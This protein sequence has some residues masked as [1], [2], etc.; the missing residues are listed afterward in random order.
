MSTNPLPR[1]QSDAERELLLHVKAYGLPEPVTQFR[2]H[3]TR[4]W[5]ADLAFVEQKVLVEVE[6]GAFRGGRHT[7]GTGFRED[8]I[9]YAEAMCLGY[10]I[11]RVMPEQIRDG[12]AIQWL[13]K[14]LTRPE[15]QPPR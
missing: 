14:I 13:S 6:G 7:T 1:R 10:R 11:L 2:F 4:K 3:P 5:T 8:C 9:K 15:A 12:Q